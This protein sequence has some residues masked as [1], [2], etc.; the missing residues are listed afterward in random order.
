[1]KKFLFFSFLLTFPVFF[2]SGCGLIDNNFRGQLADPP[3]VSPLGEKKSSSEIPPAQDDPG[4]INITEKVSKTEPVKT[5][6]LPKKEISAPVKNVVKTP[7]PVVPQRTAIQENYRRG[8]GMW[9]AFNRLSTDEKKQL[10]SIQR[11][12]PEKFRKILHEKADK[13]YEAEKI[14]QK[15]LDDL[16]LKIKTTEGEKEKENLKAVLRKKLKED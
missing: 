5:V 15:E 1:M 11:S 4:K 2:F 3:V 14:R 9:R 7:Q 13:L 8:P 16:V 6:V 10:L 12:D